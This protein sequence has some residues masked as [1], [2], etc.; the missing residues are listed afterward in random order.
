[1]RSSRYKIFER[2]ISIHRFDMKNNKLYEH[3]RAYTEHESTQTAL[4]GFL[5]GI[6]SII[7]NTA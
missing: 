7:E 6:Y 4:T 2:I 1:M 3:Q 5:N